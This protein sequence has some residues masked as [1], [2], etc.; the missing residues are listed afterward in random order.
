[1]CHCIYLLWQ[2]DHGGLFCRYCLHNS[3]RAGSRVERTRGGL[4]G[5]L[6]D[7]LNEDVAVEV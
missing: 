7:I 3:K 5:G 6:M 2:Y 4:H 1:M